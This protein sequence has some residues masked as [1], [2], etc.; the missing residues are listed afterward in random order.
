MSARRSLLRPIEKTRHQ[1]AQRIQRERVGMLREGSRF[2]MTESTHDLPPHENPQANNHRL[3]RG[4]MH[5][6]MTV[7]RNAA[8]DFAPRTV[9]LPKSL[10]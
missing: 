3:K 9:E 7:H 1:S 6:S 8:T 5:T 2:F 10:T 4:V